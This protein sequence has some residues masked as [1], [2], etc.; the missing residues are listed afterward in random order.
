[1]DHPKTFARSRESENSREVHCGGGGEKFAGRILPHSRGIELWIRLSRDPAPERRADPWQNLPSC[2]VRNEVPEGID[3]NLRDDASIEPGQE[4]WEEWLKTVTR[5]WL[6]ELKERYQAA[7][8]A[9]AAE[10]P[11]SVWGEVDS[12]K[13][14]Q[15][16]IWNLDFDVQ[17]LKKKLKRKKQWQKEKAK[18]ESTDI[19]GETF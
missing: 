1:M 13:E 8:D 2:W 7:A 9:A 17:R 3:T 19:Y 11:K 10:N 4:F 14:L 6:E 12:I 18:K 5:M 16:K 15:E